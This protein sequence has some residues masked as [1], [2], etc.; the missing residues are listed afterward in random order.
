MHINVRIMFRASYKDTD[1]KNKSG[2]WEFKAK[3]RD[4]WDAKTIC[5]EK[6]KA[7]SLIKS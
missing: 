4:L 2:K 6:R 5:T 1:K 7:L 3:K